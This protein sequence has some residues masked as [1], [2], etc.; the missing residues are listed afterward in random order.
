MIPRYP[1]TALVTNVPRT[2]H[3][4]RSSLDDFHRISRKLNEAGWPESISSNGRRVRP[5]HRL[6]GALEATTLAFPHALDVGVGE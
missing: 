6:V 2:S 4:G 3:T 1:F 5:G